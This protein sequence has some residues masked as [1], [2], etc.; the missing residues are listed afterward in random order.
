MMGFGTD[1]PQHSIIP[2]LQYSITPTAYSL[3][4]CGP[5]P[6]YEVS[7]W[8]YIVRPAAVGRPPQRTKTVQEVMTSQDGLSRLSH[9]RYGH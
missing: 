8:G 9:A 2:L 3:F 7:G 5:R 6:R 1:I 4:G